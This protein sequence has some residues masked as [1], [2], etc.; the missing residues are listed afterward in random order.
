MIFRYKSRAGAF[1]D[2]DL[3]TAD[4]PGTDAKF[5]AHGFVLVATNPKDK[6][7]QMAFA[8]LVRMLGGSPDGPQLLGPQP[9]GSTG[10]VG[11]LVGLPSKCGAVTIPI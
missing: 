10:P 7:P 1:V 11:T 8:D 2:L 9:N 6:V 4:K 3:S 5:R